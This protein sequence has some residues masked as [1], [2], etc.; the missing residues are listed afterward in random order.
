MKTNIIIFLLVSINSIT[1]F[2]QAIEMNNPFS[3]SIKN[4]SIVI[5]DSVCKE[6]KYGKIYVHLIINKEGKLIESTILR[7]DLKSLT[8]NIQFFNESILTDSSKNI[9]LKIAKY[10]PFVRNKIK[11]I[12]IHKN[13]YSQ[14]H[15]KNYAVI[16][17]SLVNK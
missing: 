15:E 9:P 13:K 11:Y 8:E 17:F 4:S 2:S 6:I 10:L 14:I 5:P 7:L 16:P 3:F 12:R 1:L